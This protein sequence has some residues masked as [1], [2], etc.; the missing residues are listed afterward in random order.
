MHIHMPTYREHMIAAIQW[1]IYFIQA[2]LLYL[3]HT[4]PI[5]IYN[6]KEKKVSYCSMTC[7]RCQPLSII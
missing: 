5:H 3:G 1:L 2:N 6:Q 7:D 4:P